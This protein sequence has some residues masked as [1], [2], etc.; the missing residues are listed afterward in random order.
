MRMFSEMTQPLGPGVEAAPG[1]GSALVVGCR[2][3]PGELQWSFRVSG[4]Q[5]RPPP[6]DEG[7]GCSLGHLTGCCPQFLIC[8][9]GI[10]HSCLRVG[11]RSEAKTI[12]ASVG[13]EVPIGSSGREPGS[14]WV[15][16]SESWRQGV[17]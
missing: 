17:L 15:E 7:A 10:N 12:P 2:P 1:L 14:Q 4:V 16:P 3:S 9:I 8:E 13:R 11:V 6:Q 5:L